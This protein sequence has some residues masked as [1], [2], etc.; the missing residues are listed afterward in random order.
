MSG[1]GPI[2]LKKSPAESCEILDAQGREYF[3]NTQGTSSAARDM[4]DDA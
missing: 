3:S 2:L 1:I 4:L